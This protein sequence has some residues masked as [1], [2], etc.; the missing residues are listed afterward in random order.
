LIAAATFATLD[1]KH[2][3]HGWQWLFIIEGEQKLR[4]I[5]FSQ[6]LI[7]CVQVLS[8]SALPSFV[9]SSSQTLL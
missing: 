9:S 3:M 4:Y 8:Q 7:S 1:N 5:E 2:G 6:K